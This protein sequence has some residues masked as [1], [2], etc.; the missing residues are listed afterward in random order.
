M[1]FSDN[2]DWSTFIEGCKST[3]R[4]L[5]DETT[6]DPLIAIED[7]IVIDVE[8]IPADTLVCDLHYEKNWN[9]RRRYTKSCSE[10]NQYTL[11][12]SGTFA[13]LCK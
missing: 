8:V 4:L 12:C 5:Q 3:T 13:C 10:V 1:Q 6:A 11:P 7:D 9:M 2:K